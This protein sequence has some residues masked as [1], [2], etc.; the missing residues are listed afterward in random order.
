MPGAFN[1][2]G[3][4]LLAKYFNLPAAVD[5]TNY[6]L[7]RS[8]MLVAIVEKQGRVPYGTQ[9]ILVCMIAT[10]ISSLRDARKKQT[11]PKIK[12]HSGI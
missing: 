6:P 4:E 8:V 12:Y 11:S 7:R 1:P 2:A 9:Q 10:N 5:E 3:D